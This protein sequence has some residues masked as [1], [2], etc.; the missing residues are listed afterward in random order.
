LPLNV[1]LAKPFAYLPYSHVVQLH[2]F[3]PNKPP[4]ILESILL[5][6]PNNANIFFELIPLCTFSMFSVVNDGGNADALD[7][8][9]GEN[10]DEVTQEDRESDI[11]K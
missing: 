7:E 3:E 4:Q 5:G 1:K 2:L 6:S 11:K 9:E 8:N 10:E